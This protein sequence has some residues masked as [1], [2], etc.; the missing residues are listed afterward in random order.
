MQKNT[1]TSFFGSRIYSEFRKSD[2]LKEAKESSFDIKDLTSS[3][4]HVIESKKNL[5]SKDRESLSQILA[6]GEDIKEALVPKNTI[7]ISPRVGTI[8]PWSSRATNIIHHCG[9]DIL[10]IE[11]IKAISFITNSGKPLSKREKEVLG[12]LLYDRMT[13]S[14]FIDQEGI[15]KLFIHHKPRPLNHI[16]IIDKGISELQSFNE[17]Q[18]LA[19][20]DD[21]IDYLFKYFSSVNRN[22]TDAELMMFAQANS[23]H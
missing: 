17:A 15:N 1:I 9:I 22:P 12:H 4:L 7:F 3:Y 14:I 20:S 10:R 8:S 11:R 16:D 23:E 6:Y 18:G 5:A 19:L 2:L 21:E 13:E